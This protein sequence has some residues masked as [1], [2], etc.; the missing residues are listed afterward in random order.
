MKTL[1]TTPAGET[2]LI[3]PSIATAAGVSHAWARTC[4]MSRFC[5]Q[6]PLLRVGTLW[7][8]VIA[9][10]PPAAFGQ[11][12]EAGFLAGQGSLHGG[13][14]GGLIGA[15][16]SFWI[17]RHVE[18]RVQ[19]AR[20]AREDAV[21]EFGPRPDIPFSEGIVVRWSERSRTLIV[22]QLLYH[23]S[24][25][26]V[27]PYAGFGI[28]KMRDSLRASCIPAGCESASP[29]WL[30]GGRPFARLVDYPNEWALAVGVHGHIVGPMTLR[31]GVTFHNPGGE[32]LSTTEFSAGIGFTF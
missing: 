7:L 26:R 24:T 29:P 5:L 27:R 28:G 13:E 4:Q 10:A 16:G 17:G 25:A 31:A 11:S 9:A 22:G 2:H 15:A 6:S 14:T 30:M 23:F 19:V 8:M 3:T 1:E 12:V 18:M 20:I 32:H 21:I